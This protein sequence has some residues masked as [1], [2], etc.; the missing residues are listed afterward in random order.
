MASSWSLV[1]FYNRRRFHQT[2]SYQTPKQVLK[3]AKS[4]TN[5][6]GKNNTAA[7]DR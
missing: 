3:A 4:S 2:L 1:Q 6:V 7:A 5:Q